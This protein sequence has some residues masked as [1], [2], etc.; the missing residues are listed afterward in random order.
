M[1]DK[2]L[3]KRQN[4][5]LIFISE[6]IDNIGFPPTRNDLS[7]HFGFRSPNA[8]ESHL[9]A[10]EK[11]GV[12]QIERGRSRGITLTALSS[13][14]LPDSAHMSLPLVGRV[15]AGS[16]ILAQE[17]IEH[18]YRIDPDL[19]SPRPH[20]FLR[21][22]GMSMRDAGIHDQDL[23]AVHRTPDIRN[24]QIV[25]A[26]IDDEV[27]VKRFRKQGHRVTLLPENPDFQAIEVDLRHQE[28]MIEGLGVGVVRNHLN[29]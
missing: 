25:V 9:R 21:V 1:N 8:A 12:I 13:A 3:T 11:K 5:V 18:T 22:E 27:T 24:G 20:Y 26:R 10:L 4:Q 28:F 15:A 16:P 23:L 7:L 19:F 6:H 17:N 29:G 2:P 14:S